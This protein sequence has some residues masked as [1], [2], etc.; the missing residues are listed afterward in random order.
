MSYLCKLLSLL[1]LVF[2]FPVPCDCV[3]PAQ[4]CY[5]ELSMMPCVSWPAW[6]LIRVAVSVPPVTACTPVYTTRVPVLP[7]PSVVLHCIAGFLGVFLRPSVPSRRLPPSSPNSSMTHTP[8][9]VS[10][11]CVW[12]GPYFDD[13]PRRVHRPMYIRC[14]CEF[15]CVC[16]SCFCAVTCYACGLLVIGMQ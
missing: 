7:T 2:T 9:R 15:V 10:K 6:V 14:L 8:S 4:R 5:C 12:G 11:I 16:L 13:A 3:Q 1:P